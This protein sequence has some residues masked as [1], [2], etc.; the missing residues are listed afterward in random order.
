MNLPN[1]NQFSEF[2]KQAFSKRRKKLKN[3]LPELYN[4]GVLKEWADNR[5]EEI[6]PDQYVKIYLLI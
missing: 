3:N 5:P 1:I 4:R 6:T 2:I